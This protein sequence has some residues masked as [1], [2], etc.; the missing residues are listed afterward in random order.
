[1]NL[2]GGII[3]TI[4]VLIC[5]MYCTIQFFHDRDLKR[6]YMHTINE[7]TES[8]EQKMLGANTLFGTVERLSNEK[9]Y[10]KERVDHL[11]KAIHTGFGLKVRTD[12]TIVNTDLL[13]I[14]YVII[15]SGIHKLLKANPEKMDDTKYYIDLIDRIQAILDKMPAIQEEKGAS[16]IIDATI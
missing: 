3:G 13:K 6:Q 14:D 2:I 7:L 4:I 1:M 15:L 5:V 12:L 9:L 16:E 8:N 10:L 11:E